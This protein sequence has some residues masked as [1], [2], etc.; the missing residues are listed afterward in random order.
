MSEEEKAALIDL[1]QSRLKYP[2]I[3]RKTG[4]AT[5]YTLIILRLAL[6][7]YMQRHKEQQLPEWAPDLETQERVIGQV[8]DTLSLMTLRDPEAAT[9]V[10]KELARG[11]RV[12]ELDE[13]YMKAFSAADR[14]VRSIIGDERARLFW[15]DATA[16]HLP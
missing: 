4:R 12:E 10:L 9:G 14:V 16:G 15:N 7:E 6:D 13:K 8:N 1:D 5:N 3:F 2:E 11:I